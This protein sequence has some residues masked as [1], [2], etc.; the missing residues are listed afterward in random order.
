MTVFLC[1]LAFYQRALREV[2]FEENKASIAYGQ[3]EVIDIDDRCSDQA[4]QT[5][6]NF[7]QESPDAPKAV[8]Q[9]AEVHRQESVLQIALLS[10]CVTPRS[11]KLVRI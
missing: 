7:T 4:P 2:L 9:P 3:T 10:V 5:S 6:V 1:V 11:M 8:H